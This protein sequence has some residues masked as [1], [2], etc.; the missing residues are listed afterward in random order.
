MET[1]V[2]FLG[3]F[4]LESFVCLYVRQKIDNFSLPRN[5]VPKLVMPTFGQGKF[6]RVYTASKENLTSV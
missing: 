2:T 4:T 3:K 6:V 5:L 1:N